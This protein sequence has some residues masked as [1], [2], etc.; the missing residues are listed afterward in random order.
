MLETETPGVKCITVHLLVVFPKVAC[1]VFNMY[2]SIVSCTFLEISP[3][4]LASCSTGYTV[5]TEIHFPQLWTKN[6]SLFFWTVLS[7]IRRNAY[8]LSC[9]LVFCVCFSLIMQWLKG[10]GWF[11][12]KSPLLSAFKHSKAAWATNSL[13]SELIYL[14][15][16]PNNAYL[17]RWDSP[18]M[19]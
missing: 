15:I 11:F 13:N 16:S 7:L 9:C 6:R 2:L 18:T 19:P 8:S 3:M 10:H 14:L 4:A 17:K 1:I 12:V 5:F